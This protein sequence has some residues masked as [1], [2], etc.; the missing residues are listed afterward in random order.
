MADA[1]RWDAQAEY[2]V[3]VLIRRYLQEHPPPTGARFDRDFARWGERL[4]KRGG[5]DLHALGV[6]H[7]SVAGKEA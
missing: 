6:R 3:G 5:E 2:D 4:V 7:L 1:R